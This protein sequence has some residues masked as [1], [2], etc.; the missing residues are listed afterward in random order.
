MKLK[1]TQT[2]ELK[3]NTEK[4]IREDEDRV[5]ALEMRKRAMEGIGETRERLGKT[6][7]EERERRSAKKVSGIFGEGN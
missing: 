1:M 6:S 3:K 7:S 5:K 4:K 2:R